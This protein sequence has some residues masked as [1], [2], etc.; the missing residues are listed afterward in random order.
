MTKETE[1]QNKIK[2]LEAQLELAE[3]VIQFYAEKE[4]V[5][6]STV[7]KAREYFKEKKE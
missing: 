7:E 1:L 4:R 5:L 2:T 3:G 6:C